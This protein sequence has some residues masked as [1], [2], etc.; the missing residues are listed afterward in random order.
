MRVSEFH[1][2]CEGCGMVR[3]GAEVSQSSTEFCKDPTRVPE[4]FRK[5]L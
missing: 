5:V 3:G 2:F 1:G 4:M